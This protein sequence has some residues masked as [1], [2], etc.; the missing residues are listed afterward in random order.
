MFA[1]PFSGIARVTA[2]A[3][4]LA[5]AGAHAS[6]QSD[7]MCRQQGAF[8]EQLAQL[9]DAGIAQEQAIDRIA[10]AHP[11]VKRADVA[12]AAELLF[13]RFRQMPA[14]QVAH[15]FMLACMDD[16]D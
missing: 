3:L 10:G 16:A 7:A 1:R 11:D 5:A 6:P 14:D 15:E 12:D 4:L 13:H 2:F 9:R 8:A